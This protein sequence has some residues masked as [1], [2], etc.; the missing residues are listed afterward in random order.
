MEKLCV[1]LAGD[2]RD[3]NKNSNS[4]EVN[5]ENLVV[6]ENVEASDK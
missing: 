4:N 5:E 2:L 1:E 6:T 3:A